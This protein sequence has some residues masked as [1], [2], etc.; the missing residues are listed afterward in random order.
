MK[1]IS[2]K[3]RKRTFARAQFVETFALETL[4]CLDMRGAE[5][6]RATSMTSDVGE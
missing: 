3:L 2:K 6:R 1:I 5:R 4:E